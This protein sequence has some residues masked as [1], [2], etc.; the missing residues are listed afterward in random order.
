MSTGLFQSGS[1]GQESGSGRDMGGCGPTG[2]GGSA[3]AVPAR[4]ER[5]REDRHLVER[6][7][8]AVLHGSSFLTPTG[9][10]H[11]DLS[12]TALLTKMPPL[13]A[14]SGYSRIITLAIYFYSCLPSADGRMELS[15][16]MLGS[17]SAS[18]ATLLHLITFDEPFGFS[19]VEAVACGTPV[20]A[21]RRGSMP[22]LIDD[23][24]AVPGRGHDD[25][26]CHG[27]H[28]CSVVSQH[29]L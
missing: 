7:Q 26:H 16:T 17:C 1:S 19:V 18:L 28:D 23:A 21:F 25:V 22:E 10:F 29:K 27:R 2:S 3:V 5:H 8:K 9:A 24:A 6:R 15:R 12:T 13:L 4:V 14:L 11:S 20:V